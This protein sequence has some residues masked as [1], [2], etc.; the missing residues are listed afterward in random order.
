MSAD[1]RGKSLCRAHRKVWPAVYTMNRMCLRSE[2]QEFQKCSASVCNRSKNLARSR[3]QNVRDCWNRTD[4]GFVLSVV[5][6]RPLLVAQMVGR[7]KNNN[8]ERICKET[9]VANVKV[10]LHLPGSTEGNHGQYLDG[11]S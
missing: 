5:Y 7:F 4:Y 1:W 11:W 8:L 9:V 2:F 3:L 6:L 10:S